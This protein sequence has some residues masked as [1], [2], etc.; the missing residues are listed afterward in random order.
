[1]APYS[2]ICQ[3]IFILDSFFNTYLFNTPENNMVSLKDKLSAMSN[4]I[5][6]AKTILDAEFNRKFDVY[7][8]YDS[9]NTKL[10]GNTVNK[11]NIYNAD[12]IT[13]SFVKKALNIVIKNTGT[14]NVKFYSIFPG[15]IDIP[16]LLCGNQFY[17]QY[18]RHY[19]RVPIFIDNVLSYQTL[20]QWVYFRQDNPYTYKDVYYNN[21]S[22]DLQDY[23]SLLTTQERLTFTSINTYMKR[24]YDS[25][26]LGYR[27]RN[28]GEIKNFVQA[29]WI[30]LDYKGEGVF[31]QLGDTLNAEGDLAQQYK[32]KN[33]EFFIYENN[34]SNNYLNRFEDISGVNK[35]GNTIYLD[36]ESSI[37][38]FIA[39]NSVNGVNPGTATF[40]GAFLFPDIEGRSSILTNGGNNDYIEV[41]VGKSISIPITFEFY[42][43][44]ETTS[45]I[46]KALYFDLRDSLINEPV[47]YMIE[48][49]AN[50]DYTSTGSLINSTML[51]DEATIS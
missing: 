28:T 4:D 47:H 15:N 22:Q 41:E 11:I 23:K 13:D 25:P 31:N 40:T 45:Q 24:D 39:K 5:E 44:G 12:H 34:L 48:L 3:K 38:E 8:T 19:E 6:S 18:I 37:S 30:G 32:N 1:M 42:I 43:D 33:I 20:G 10:F 16:L 7:I 17:E 2:I 36:R 14:S 51:I 29:T 46:T 21:E 50:Y 26:L 27:K 35:Q 49:T 9:T